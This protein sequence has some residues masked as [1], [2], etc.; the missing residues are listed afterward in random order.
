MYL[1][2]YLL[3]T[4]CIFQPEGWV[5]RKEKKKAYSN[6]TKFNGLHLYMVLQFSLTHTHTQMP[7]S[8]LGFNQSCP[9]TLNTLNHVI[10][11]WPPEP[12]LSFFL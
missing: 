7:A 9:R 5:D 4:D 2:I 3:R 11:V 12:N 1:F 8:T 6:Y 10:N